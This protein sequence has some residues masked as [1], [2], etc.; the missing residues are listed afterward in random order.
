MG[1]AKRSLTP[2]PKAINLAM[3][4]R[5]PVPLTIISGGQTGADRAGLDAAIALDLRYGGWCPRGGWAEDLPLPPGLLARYP[6]LRETSS[7]A[8]SERTQFNVRNSDA[9][10]LLV[11]SAGLDV[12]KG[13]CLTI[14]IARTMR[15]PFLVLNIED[16]ASLDAAH[17][18][19]ASL[20]RSD[21]LNIAGPRESEAPGLYRAAYAFLRA[22]LLKRSLVQ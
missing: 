15:R 8:T 9:T 2:Q 4:K 13:A 10:L 14:E 7:V 21:V 19:L 11:L 6:A 3:A 5:R 1:L 12:S 18:W 16:R 17:D 22:L 20:K